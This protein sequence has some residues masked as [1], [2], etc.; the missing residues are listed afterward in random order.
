MAFKLEEAHQNFPAWSSDGQIA[1]FFNGKYDNAIHLLSIFKD[2]APFYSEHPSNR[3]RVVWDI[4]NQFI[5]ASVRDETSQG[6]LYRVEIDTGISAPLIQGTGEDPTSDIFYAPTISP[7]GLRIAF[8]RT[9]S[10]YMDKDGNA[11]CELWIANIDGSNP[12]KLAEKPFIWHPAW[13]PD[14]N[15]LGFVMAEI[16]ESS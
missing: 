5:I 15:I 9:G 11:R 4:H 1:Y 8:I 2:G 3:S 7:D 16:N 10:A 12:Q 14:P 13:S 6:A